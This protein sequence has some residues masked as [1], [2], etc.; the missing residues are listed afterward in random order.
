M[1]FQSSHHLAPLP[2]GEHCIAAE[3]STN[4]HK[5]YA[6]DGQP[7]GS[8]VTIMQPARSGLEALAPLE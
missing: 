1:I 7:L 8:E 3:L 5:I 6:I 2:P 4:E